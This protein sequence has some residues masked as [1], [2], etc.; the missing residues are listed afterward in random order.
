MSG[1]QY[2]AWVEI[3]IDGL[4][5]VIV[6]PTGSSNNDHEEEPEEKI[7][8]NI[9]PLDRVKEYD[10]TPLLPY[11]FEDINTNGILQ[12]IE[13]IDTLS[14][15][16]LQKLFEQG[17]YYEIKILGEQT[18][19]GI[20][21][22]IIE[23][24][25][26]FDSDG[27]DVTDKYEIT[28]VS[29]KLEVVSQ[30]IELM[31]Y[32]QMKYYTGDTYSYT[33]DMVYKVL[34]LPTDYSLFTYDIVG[35]ITNVGEL[36]AEITN[37]VL[38]DKNGND[39]SKNYRFSCVGKIEVKQRKLIIQTQSAT[40]EYDGNPLTNQKWWIQMG[41]LVPGDSIVALM[42]SSITEVGWVENLITI[43]EIS[44]KD[45]VDVKINYDIEVNA[46]MLIVTE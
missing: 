27:N 22:S 37:V 33:N 12:L 43:L 24:F 39:I 45:G 11:D 2:H 20:S 21:E 38:I 13:G 4:G 41:Q 8:L 40:K 6:D 29:G 14:Q 36:K 32:N 19:V 10:G 28:F 46:G 15:V 23:S 7:Q 18:E 3:Y 9:K 35:S 26:L 31:F 42:S 5:W 25:N 30:L 44:N 17:Y 34:G 1:S 16:T